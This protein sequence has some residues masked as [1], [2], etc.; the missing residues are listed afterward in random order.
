MTKRRTFD[1]HKGN[2]QNELE[3][4]AE[5]IFTHGKITETAYND[6]DVCFVVKSKIVPITY[7]VHVCGF[8][9]VEIIEEIAA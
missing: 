8:R 7:W 9:I 3:R 1:S 5:D 4:F 6:C 2:T